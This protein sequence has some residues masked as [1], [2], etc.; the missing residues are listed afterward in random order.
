MDDG[1]MYAQC[2]NCGEGKL[3]P[4]FNND[5]TNMYVCTKCLMQFGNERVILNY[6]DGA[7][8]QGEHFGY[9][10]RIYLRQKK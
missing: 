5:G 10:P 6:S 4:F 9:Y 3:L 1:C 2:H 7:N 8:Q